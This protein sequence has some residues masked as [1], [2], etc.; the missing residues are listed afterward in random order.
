M[1]ERGTILG[2][3]AGSN[4]LWKGPNP[5][6]IQKAVISYHCHK[7]IKNTVINKLG[8]M[9]S[10]SKMNVKIKFGEHPLTSLNSAFNTQCPRVDCH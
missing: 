1:S 10:I 2:F 5:Y 7:G 4:Q 8:G 9:T 6:N 3:A